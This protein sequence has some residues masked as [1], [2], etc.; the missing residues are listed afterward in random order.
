M[1][2]TPVKDHLAILFLAW[3]CVFLI[4]DKDFA[5]VLVIISLQNCPHLVL[6]TVYTDL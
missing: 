6:C 3:Q 4:F 5:L 2:T 1:A